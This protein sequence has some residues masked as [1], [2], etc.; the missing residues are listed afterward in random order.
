MYIHSWLRL[1]LGGMLQMQL[2]LDMYASTTSGTS[3]FP[4]IFGPI[5]VH[6]RGQYHTDARKEDQ[7]EVGVGAVGYLSDTQRPIVEAEGLV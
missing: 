6:S 1:M 2:A 3:S 7:I 5:V 4:S